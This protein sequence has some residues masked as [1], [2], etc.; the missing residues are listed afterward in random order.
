MRPSKP[1]LT[2]MILGLVGVL[3]GV[4]FKL[5]HLM[6][7]EPLFNAGVLALVVGLLAWVVALF[8]KKRA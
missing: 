8:R 5:N 3:L 6:G 1:A 4:T 7:A 2:L